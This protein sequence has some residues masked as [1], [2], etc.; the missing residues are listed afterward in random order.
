[1]L[2]SFDENWNKKYIKGYG[3]YYPS[4]EIIRFIKKNNIVDKKILDLGCG[5]GRHLI[6][7]EREGNNKVFGIDGSIY[8]LKNSLYHKKKFLVSDFL[9]LPFKKESFDVII[10]YISLTLNTTFEIRIILQQL[11]YILKKN[12]ILF[13]VVLGQKTDGIKSG[14]KL[15]EHTYKNIKYGIARGKRKVHFFTIKEI[16]QLLKLFGFKLTSLDITYKSC[17]NRQYFYEE[18]TILA[19]KK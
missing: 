11:N 14:Y 13:S 18:Y 6:L 12:G 5:N 1:M 16:K 19:L 4:E 10:D 17:D 7:L 8:A 3:A 2:K 9:Y 15:D